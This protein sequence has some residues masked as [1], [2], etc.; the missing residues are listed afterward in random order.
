[1]NENKYISMNDKTVRL[2]NVTPVAGGNHNRKKI[3]TVERKIGN[4]TF[5]VASRMNDGK[6]RDLAAAV[7]RIIE[8][9]ANVSEKTLIS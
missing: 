6:S 2:H 5:I 4:T 3:R 7:A 9:N 8:Q 1:M